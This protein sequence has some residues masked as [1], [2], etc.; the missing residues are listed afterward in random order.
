MTTF[1]LDQNISDA[2]VVAA[3]RADGHGD[4]LALPP[5]LRDVLDPELLAVVLAGS[6]PL[7]TLDR[8]LP[9]DH[10]AHIPDLNPG[11]IVVTNYPDRWRTMTSRL[12]LRVL[13]K[14]KACFPDWHQCRLN[15]SILEITAEGVAVGHVEQGKFAS[16]DYYEFTDETW[17]APLRAALERNASRGPPRISAS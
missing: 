10:S 11:I 17:P 8:H 15:N 9:P 13:A 12:A 3:C 4:A 2:R 7:M 16:G 6:S 14:L 1:Q 5:E